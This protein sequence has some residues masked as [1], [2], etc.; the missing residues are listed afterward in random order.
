MRSTRQREEAVVAGEP[1]A[2]EAHVEI[3]PILVGVVLDLAAPAAAAEEVAQEPV[4][5]ARD[6]LDVRS[7][8]QAHA[9]ILP[10][11]PFIGSLVREVEPGARAGLAGGRPGPSTI[12]SPTWRGGPTGR[13]NL[14]HRSSREDRSH[15]S[16]LRGSAAG[17]GVRR[18][19]RRGRRRRGRGRAVRRDQRRPQLHP[20]RH[21]RSPQGDGR[22]GPHPR[23]HRLRGHRGLRRRHHLPADAAE[24]EPR[25]G[26]HAGQGRHRQAGRRTCGAASSSP[27]RA[28]PIR[29]PR[30]TSWRRSSRP[31]PGSPPASTSTSPSRPSASTP[32]AP[33]TRPR[34]RPRSSA[35]SRRPA[36]R[37]RSRST[38]P[39]STTSSRSA[40]PRSPR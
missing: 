17:D 30:A 32:A 34:A 21:Q 40:P 15:R 20:G 9:P 2:G 26:P 5:V 8:H 24:R 19:R 39:R 10:V 31:A 14:T 28:P 13:V 18:G 1:P 7:L 3:Q 38:G 25:A 4:E 12:E 35:V 23:H 16:R 27:S 33:T 37:G 22:Q 36:P 11:G 29:A 6:A